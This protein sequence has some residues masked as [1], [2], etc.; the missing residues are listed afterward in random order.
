MCSSSCLDFV[1]GWLSRE[2]VAGKRILEVGAFNVNG[3]ARAIVEALEPAEYIGTDIQ[4]GAGVDVVIDAEELLDRYAPESFDGL[5]ST[6]MLE[7]CG[8]WRRVIEVM[9]RLVKPYGWLLL[10]TRSRGFPYHEHP[11]DHWRF[12]VADMQAIFAD[13][14]T[15][16]ILSDPREP[17]VFVKVYKPVE[18][19]PVDLG[20]IKVL[21]IVKGQP[22]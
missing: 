21:E 7:H 9:K 2:D 18:W 11:I 1:R 19:Q 4:A 14:T 20:A 6:E 17:G 15:S 3:S 13:F 8:D 12:E 5:I 10:T 16:I 22:Q